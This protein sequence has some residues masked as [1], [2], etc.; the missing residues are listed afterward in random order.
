MAAYVI[1]DVT[2]RDP[3]ALDTYRARASDSI[4]RHGGRYL[5]R[6][7]A[8]EAVEGSWQP[9]HVIIVE[10]PDLA[11]AR[12]WYRSPEYA[13]A[14]DVRDRALNRNLIFVDGIAPA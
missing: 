14:L 13:A 6:G 11:R 7:G 8:I 5:A 10:F 4:A 2:F 9:E 3:A 1:S 12:A